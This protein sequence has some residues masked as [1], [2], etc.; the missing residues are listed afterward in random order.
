MAK[1]KLIAALEKIEDLQTF[2]EQ[3]QKENEELKTE[4]AKERKDSEFAR[5]M[6]NFTLKRFSK[7]KD[8]V[9]SSTESMKLFI[10]TLEGDKKNEEK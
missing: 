2:V 8:F 5:E 4:L 10:E 9:K 1:N 3:L 6:W 7:L